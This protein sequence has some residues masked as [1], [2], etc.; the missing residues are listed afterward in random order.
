MKMLTCPLAQPAVVGEDQPNHTP[1][2]LTQISALKLC[3]KASICL[4]YNG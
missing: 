2:V 1:D 3:F 4:G